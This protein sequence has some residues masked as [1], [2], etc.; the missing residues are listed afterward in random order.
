MRKN[1]AVRAERSMSVNEATQQYRPALDFQNSNLVVPIS[2]NRINPV[3][4]R[5]MSASKSRLKLRNVRSV[6][7]TN[8]RAG[9]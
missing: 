2:N 4:H 6:A 1:V 5:E 8:I 7:P 9:A 3:I